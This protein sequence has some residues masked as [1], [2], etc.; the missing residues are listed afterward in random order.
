M[1]V[2]VTVQPASARDDLRV[3]VFINPL[4]PFLGL[5]NLG[6]ELEVESQ[7]SVWVSAEYAAFRTGYLDS[8]D[9]PDVVGTLGVRHY[10]SPDEPDASSFFVGLTGGFLRR[11]A[12][13][14]RPARDVVLG[15]EVGYRFL[16]ESDAYVSP[17]ALLSVPVAEKAVLPGAEP[18]LGLFL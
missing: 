7:Y 9:H 15:A 17:R 4:K 2:L 18:L 10:V 13:N 8:I 14:S 16:L 3:S 6:V 11:S 12:P 5:L 1:T